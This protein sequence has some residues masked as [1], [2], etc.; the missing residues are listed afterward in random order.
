[1]NLGNFKTRVPLHDLGEFNPNWQGIYSPLYDETFIRKYIH[2]QFLENSTTYVERYQNF[3]RWANYLKLAQRFFSFNSE[4]DLRILDIGSGSGNTVFP[5]MDCYPNAQIVASDLSIPLLKALK[6]HYEEHYPSKTCFIV[7]LNAEDMI[8]EPESI[9]LIVGGAILHHLFDPYKTLVECYKTLK[10][11]GI[12]V[13]YEPFEIGNQIVSIIFEQLLI[14][15]DKYSTS[16]SPDDSLWTRNLFR[17]NPPVKPVPTLPLEVKNFFQ[18]WCF[19][20]K[21]R[22]GMD[23]SDPKFQSMDDKWL[24]TRQYF[25]EMKKAIGFQELIIFPIKDVQNLFFEQINVYLELVFGTGI[26]LLPEWANAQIH[27][28]DDHFSHHLRQD[29][30]TE[31]GILF[32]K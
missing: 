23:K 12:A 11:G 6:D 27:T 14:L 24:F 8:F 5:L 30:M 28:F 15:D 31:G 21:A 1:M 3:S 25:E 32:R 17:K 16:N 9:D 10:P 29:L 2:D 22:Q 7:Q 19:D 4:D 26:S 18:S 13:F 20:L